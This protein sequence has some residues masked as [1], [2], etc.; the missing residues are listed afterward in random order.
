MKDL[1]NKLKN[2]GYIFKE[3]KPLNLKDFGIRKRY[4]VYEGIDIKNRY[5]LIIEIDR[6]SRFLSKDALNILELISKISDEKKH[7]FKLN[8]LYITS[9]VCSK[10]KTLLNGNG[11]K[12]VD[13]SL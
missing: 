8:I 3:L 5:S 6:K 12:I 7:S 1:V 9:P 2:A 11:V 4:K 13:A 10:A